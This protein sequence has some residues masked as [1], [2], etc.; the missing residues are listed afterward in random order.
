MAEKSDTQDCLTRGLFSAA[1]SRVSMVQ[2]DRTWRAVLERHH[3]PPA[4]ESILGELMAAA[5]LL[6]S[7]IKNDGQLKLEIRGQGPLTLVAIECA[8][9]GNMRGLAR[10]SEPFAASGDLQALTGGGLLVMTTESAKG[11]R[12]QGI[13]SLEGDKV[14]TVLER[15]FRD[16]EQLPTRLW[17]TTSD[18]RASGFLL[19]QLPGEREPDSWERLQY[20][21]ETVTDEELLTLPAEQLFYRLYHQETLQLLPTQGFRFHC[22]CSRQRV[23]DMLV[24]LG[25]QEIEET[26]AQEGE[27]AVD[28][29]FCNQVYRFDQQA[30]IALF[31]PPNQSVL[32]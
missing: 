1:S 17:L 28:C 9:D 11:K 29:E 8:A 14:A 25:R 10:W 21:S 26:L 6:A 2:L 27:V 24:S 13:V 16:S 3:Y 30:A 7:T 5:A 22:G 32:H 15:Y 4:I 23:A 20:L 12:Y 18:Q 19:Q 31:G